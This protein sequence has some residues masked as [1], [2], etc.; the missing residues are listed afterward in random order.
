M[1]YEDK[2]SLNIM[3]GLSL[4]NWGYEKF[5]PEVASNIV[6]CGVRQRQK[7]GN[8]LTD[9]RRKGGGGGGY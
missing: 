5:I 6:T 3:I 1:K 9:R 8:I 7:Y 4:I 2:E